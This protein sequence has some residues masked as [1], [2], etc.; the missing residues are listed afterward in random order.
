MP[1]AGIAYGVHE[2]SALGAA[3]AMHMLVP[4]DRGWGRRRLRSRVL[5]VELAN[6]ANQNVTES[7]EILVDSAL[8][9]SIVPTAV[10]E[11]LGIRPWSERDFLLADG[12]RVR[13]KMGGVLLKQRDHITSANV[14]FGDEG[15]SAR[16]GKLALEALG[17][18]LD[19]LPRREPKAESERRRRRGRQ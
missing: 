14:V 2:S 1:P 15:E 12:S 18:S 3:L 6:L 19:R 8:V 16:L 17:F 9:Y 11:R 7:L 13:R 4:A 10:L 5:R